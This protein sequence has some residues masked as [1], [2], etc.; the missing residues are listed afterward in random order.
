MRI[1]R[2]L[3]EKKRAMERLTEIHRQAI[4]FKKTHQEILDEYIKLMNDLPKGLPRWVRDELRT[5]DACW[6]NWLHGFETPT[7]HQQ[8]LEYCTKIDGKLV[9]NR[10]QSSRWYGKA[11]YEA[12]DLIERGTDA[13][14]YWV[15]TDKP[16]FI[17]GGR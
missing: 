1:E 15:D 2:A 7:G 3:K 4:H 12:R 11:G 13:G 14:Y 10:A 6:H 17:N 8:W 9:S 5:V 16:F